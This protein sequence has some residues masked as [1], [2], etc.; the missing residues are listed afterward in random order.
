VQISSLSNIVTFTANGQNSQAMD[1]SNAVWSWGFNVGNGSTGYQLTPVPLAISGKV[2][3][4]G[5]G[6]QD[7][8]SF[9]KE[10]GSIWSFG[11]N[12]FDQIGDGTAASRLTPV[13]SGIGLYF[14][15]FIEH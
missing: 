4:F 8:A 1:A 3:A 5:S 12:D 9:L 14:N 13:L 7:T 2:K 10:D 15:I 11:G 6:L